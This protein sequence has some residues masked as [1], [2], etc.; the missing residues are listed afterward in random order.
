MA[1]QSQA[2]NRR[3]VYSFSVKA[4]LPLQQRLLLLEQTL[5]LKSQTCLWFIADPV[6]RSME[7]AAWKPVVWHGK[8]DIYYNEFPI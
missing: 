7:K 4:F 2:Q 5:L 6:V 3:H 1:I 8:A